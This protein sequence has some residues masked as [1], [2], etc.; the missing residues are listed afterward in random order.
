MSRRTW[1]VARRYALPVAAV[2]A[3]LLATGR[4]RS[5]WCAVGVAGVATAFFRDPE[6]PLN[7]IVYAAA[8]GLVTAVETDVRD[9]WLPDGRGDR[10]GRQAEGS[11]GRCAVETNRTPG[12]GRPR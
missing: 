12:A 10:R 6:R 8:D 4:R 2:G 5:G 1:P 7:H 11:A 3:L 9:A